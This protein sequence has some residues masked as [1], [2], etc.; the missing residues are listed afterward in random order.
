MCLNAMGSFARRIQR[1]EVPH[2]WKSL[3]QSHSETE[4]KI[5]HLATDQS[6][7][8]LWY[9][10]VQY[11]GSGKS[12]NA[13]RIWRTHYSIAVWIQKRMLMLS[14]KL[15]MVFE[16]VYKRMTQLSLL[17]LVILNETHVITHINFL[18]A[19][20]RMDQLC[21]FFEFLC[22]FFPTEDEEIRLPIHTFEEYNFIR[23][24]MGN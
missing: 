23:N 13:F 5:I 16:P 14:Y 21:F 6:N 17:V 7:F 2:N 4:V 3:L 12:P 9:R 11:L 19:F 20:G 22:S 18:T 10:N 1:G 8:P 24:H 15:L